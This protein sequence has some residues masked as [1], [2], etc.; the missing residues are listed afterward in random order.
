MSN[1]N[2]SISVPPAALLQAFANPRR[3]P[4]D[5]AQQQRLAQASHSR[6]RHADG[7]LAL[8][9]F[10]E[11][12]R[13]V[14]LHG[15]DGCAA[16]ML[17]FVDPLL[18]AGFA[19][20]L[21]DAPAHGQSSGEVTSVVHIGEALLSVCDTLGEVEAVIAHSA[22][23]AGSLWAFNRGLRVNASVHLC[24]P[25]SLRRMLLGAGA[26]YGLDQAQT[27]ALLA[28]AQDHIGQPLVALDIENMRDG[29]THRGLIFHDPQDRTVPFGASQALHQNWPDS[30][31][32]E[33]SGLGHRRL[34]SDAQVIAQSV[35]FIAGRKAQ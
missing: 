12:P 26:A 25:S 17:A 35:A 15:W 4:L 31:L 14:L 16:Q 27:A 22:G 5:D 33:L 34:L 20:T 30:R 9:S 23:S 19:V 21:L 1:L 13:V 24:G 32:V 3:M 2:T 11:G 28:W 10:G 6:H 29:L 7:E 18:A 8:W